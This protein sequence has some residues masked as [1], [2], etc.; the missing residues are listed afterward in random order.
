M[1]NDYYDQLDFE[2]KRYLLNLNRDIQEELQ[3]KFEV[4]EIIESKR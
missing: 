1:L 3:N 4:E 2:T